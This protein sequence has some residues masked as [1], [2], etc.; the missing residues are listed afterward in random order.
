MR[1]SIIFILL[2]FITFVSAQDES[3]CTVSG[4]HA[5]LIDKEIIHPAADEDCL[6]CHESNDKEHPKAGGNE[7]TLSDDGSELCYNCHDS[8]Q[9]MTNV[10]SPVEDGECLTGH[11]PHSSDYENL[12][13]DRPGK[14]YLACHEPES[15][16]PYVHGPVAGQACTACH[17]PQQRER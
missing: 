9:I 14:L 15:E 17:R 5:A 4:C 16:G 3:S 13:K 12:T 11:N 10:H 1:L 2:A 6:N 8:K 7:F